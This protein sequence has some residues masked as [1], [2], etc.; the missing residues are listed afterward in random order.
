MSQKKDDITDDG[1]MPTTRSAVVRRLAA[2][3]NAASDR[4]RD[5]CF[6]VIESRLKGADKLP[7]TVRLARAHLDLVQDEVIARYT[8]P[9]SRDSITS[10]PGPG[11]AWTV[12]IEVVGIDVT[13]L[14]FA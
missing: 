14:V 4:A 9:L 13:D 5:F 2:E 3:S 11:P 10:N 12:T 8:A 7:V 6:D 1:A